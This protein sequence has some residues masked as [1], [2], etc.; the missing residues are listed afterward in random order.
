MA[1][2]HKEPEEF[3]G[4]SAQFLEFVKTAKETG[5]DASEAAFD[6]ALGKLAPAKPSP[7]PRPK[8]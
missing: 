5:A 6:K 8:G 4:S 2:K 3:S 7:K 1:G